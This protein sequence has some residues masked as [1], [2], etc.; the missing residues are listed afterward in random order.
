MKNSA[1]NSRGDVGDAGFAQS[2]GA[3][4]AA[5]ASIDM[6]GLDLQTRIQLM[7]Q[8]DKDGDGRLSEEERA[9]A[10]KALREKPP[11]SP[12]CAKSLRGR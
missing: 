5:Q 1:H 6:S 2:E 3:E 10:M 11:T 4:K 8:F 7:K 12:R 9:E